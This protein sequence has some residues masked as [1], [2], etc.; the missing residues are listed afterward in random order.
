MMD[1]SSTKLKPQNCWE[2]HNCPKEVR[3]KC[4]AYK[5]GFGKSCWVWSSSVK[6]CP[7]A[8]KLGSCMNCKWYKKVG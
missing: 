4:V 6:K 8:K 2:F 3:E 5:E 1:V 7:T